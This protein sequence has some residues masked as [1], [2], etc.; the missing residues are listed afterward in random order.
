MRPLVLA[1]AF[2]I[3]V[4]AAGRAAPAGPGAADTLLPDSTR[5]ERF[6]LAN[7]LRVVVR[8]VPGATRIAVT[9]AY[10]AGQASDPDGREGLASLLA[11]IYY[12]GPTGEIPARTR[13]EMPSLRPQ[14]WNFSVS[15]LATV[16]TEMASREQFPGVL[17]QVAS[18]MKG[19]EPAESDLAAARATVT[20]E[21][22]SRYS[23]RPELALYYRVG[24]QAQGRSD[25]SIE[26]YATGRP[27]AAIRLDEVRSALAARFVPANAALAIAGDL[28]AFP[29]RAM[30]DRELG[31]IP[32]GRRLAAPALRADTASRVMPRDDIASPLGVYAVRAPALS[33][34]AHP[35]FLYAAL[36]LGSQASQTFGPPAPP[37]T[38]RFQY[39]LFDDP[40]LMRLYPAL[41]PDARS[42]RELDGSCG[43]AFQ[44]FRAHGMSPDILHSLWR[45]VDWLLGGPIPPELAARVRTDLG[46]LAT[47]STTAAMREL[48]GGEEF[49]SAYRERF[50]RVSEIS[51]LDWGGTLSDP[52]IASRLLLLPRKT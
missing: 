40:S 32:A 14:G 6:T 8:Q 29:V 51:P 21:L 23:G 46:A 1:L 13:E 17:H 12:L 24:A 44:D 11:E 25:A 52:R 28:A 36:L 38:T 22:R 7:G 33:D 16:F 4:P 37:L 35:Q 43:Q 31:A 20:A 5:L 10:D 3:L 42:L 49:W 34:S 9:V 15:P 18:R 30:L 47:L 2:A 26:R 19:V 41:E 50:R 45:G 48:W 27:L 39:N